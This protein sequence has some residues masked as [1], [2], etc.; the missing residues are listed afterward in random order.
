MF[1]ITAKGAEL[2]VRYQDLCHGA[3]AK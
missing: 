2:L 3:S 1:N